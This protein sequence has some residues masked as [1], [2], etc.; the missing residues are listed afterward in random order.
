MSTVVDLVNQDECV[1]CGGCTNSC[2]VEALSMKENHEGFLNPSLDRERCISCGM[3]IKAC[4]KIDYEKKNAVAPKVFAAY[5]IPEIQRVSSSGGLFTVFANVVLKMGGAVCGAAYDENLQVV[6]KVVQDEEGLSALRGSKYV[7]S[8]TGNIYAEVRQMLEEGRKVLFSGTPCQV[9]A[10]NKF[11]EHDYDNLLTI[12]IVCHGVPS[13]RIFHQYLKETTNGKPVKNVEFRSKRFG[14]SCE[15]ILI[16]YDDASEYEGSLADDPY[17]K[18]FLKN[19]FLRKSCQECPFSEFPRCG[20]ITLGDFWGLRKIDPALVSRLGTSIVF[21]NNRKGE[22]WYD[23]IADQ[24]AMSTLMPFEPERYPNRIHKTYRHNNGRSVFFETVE[25]DGVRKAVNSITIPKGKAEPRRIVMDDIEKH[26]IKKHD[27]GLVSNY[28]AGNFGGSL[29]QLALYHILKDLGYSVLMIEHHKD[30]RA[31]TSLNTMKKIYLEIPYP[32][33][34]LAPMFRNKLSMRALNDICDTFVVGSDQLFQFA[35]FQAQGEF[36]TLDWVDD[37][38]KKIAMAASFGHSFVWGDSIKTKEM[39][40]FM[41]RFDAFSV[42]EANAVELCRDVY[43]VDAHWISDPV[44]LCNEKLYQDLAA[45]STRTWAENLMGAY[46]LDPS[47]EKRDIIQQLEDRLNLKCELFSEFGAGER[48]MEPLRG[49]SWG[50]YC[51]EDRLSIFKHSRFF[52][53]DSFHAT[54][55]AIIF[56]IPFISILNKKR[57]ADRFYSLLGH[58]GLENH[59]VENL[60]ALKQIENLTEID[61]DRVHALLAADR[62]DSMKWL[63]EALEK[64]KDGERNDYNILSDRLLE[65]ENEIEQ[66]K[67]MI[68][69]LANEMGYDVSAIT[70]INQY[71]TALRKN[72]DRFTVYIAVKDTPGMALNEEISKKIKQLGFETELKNQHWHSFVGILDKGTVLYEGLSEENQPISKTMKV[73]QQTAHVE[74]RCLKAG[75]EARIVINDA[76]YAINR[77]GL[78]F[79][80]WDNG[81]KRVVDAVCFD[82]HN[83]DLPCYRN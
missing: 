57:G 1:G 29:T 41:Q 63:R 71:L 65:Q 70:D 3:C 56:R 53:T 50:D 11:L 52:V 32:P 17:V 75:N 15:H 51:V 20:D 62:E 2:P 46:I 16:T 26:Q 23:K 12:D 33:E 13:N 30:C 72:I 79:V 8:N 31:T 66:L 18:G 10:L 64:P 74:S 25:R 19:V 73:N 7:Q 21:L 59:L 61:F 24:L 5:A 40:H 36:V 83:R 81:L 6:H 49:V 14:W 44:F 69:M 39:S 28:Y 4:P 68:S 47:E 82:T 34:D 77:R 35:L 60:D 76:D 55:L 67:A 45:K 38:K 58:F 78:N 27:I 54:C 43:H 9:A 48:Y 22:D 80:I 37:T 42:R